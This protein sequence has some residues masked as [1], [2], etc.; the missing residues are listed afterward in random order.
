VTRADQ[1][2]GMALGR[3]SQAAV[4]SATPSRAT[5]F[6]SAGNDAAAGIDTIPGEKILEIAPLHFD[7]NRFFS[8][9]SMVVR[10]FERVTSYG[11]TRLRKVRSLIRRKCLRLT[12]RGT[13]Y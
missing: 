2:R 5:M 10:Q 1:G 7:T 8:S 3:W 9:L 13:V 12:D 11:C 6:T 4:A